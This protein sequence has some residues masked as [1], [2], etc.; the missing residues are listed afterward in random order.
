MIAVSIF[1]VL[2]TVAIIVGVCVAK[3]NTALNKE[4][5]QSTNGEN[6]SSQGNDELGGGVEVE[7]EKVTPLQGNTSLTPEREVL[8]EANIVKHIENNQSRMPLLNANKSYYTDENGELISEEIRVRDYSG[9][10]ENLIVIANSFAD[11]GYPIE[12]I[13]YAQRLY[14]EYYEYFSNYSSEELLGGLKQ[15]FGKSGNTLEAVCQRAR[16]VFGI[17]REDNCEFVFDEVMPPVDLTP[18]FYAVEINLPHEWKEEYEDYCI[19]DLWVRGLGEN[20]YTQNTEHNLHIIICK[21]LEKGSSEYDIRLAQL[22]YASY[23]ADI[24]YRVDW[25]E[26]IVMLFE[27]ETPDYVFLCESMNEIFGEDM[28]SNMFIA[29]YYDGISEYLGGAKK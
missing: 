9:M 7:F 17:E 21:M 26:Q 29:N 14:F 15:V 11:E 18:Y 22:L 20:E 27:E 16:D 1:A 23:I 25:L 19:C 24:K 5:N 4:N 6:N 2:L 13:W 3:N 12:P 10:K 28:N 8:L